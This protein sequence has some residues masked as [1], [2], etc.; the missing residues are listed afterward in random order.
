MIASQNCPCSMDSL[1]DLKTQED[2]R[3]SSAILKLLTPLV[4]HREVAVPSTLYWDKMCIHK[5]GAINASLR[6]LRN[7]DSSLL[8]E[9]Y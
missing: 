6:L 3:D 4:W 7:G 8:L 9:I 5:H 1:L 2:Y